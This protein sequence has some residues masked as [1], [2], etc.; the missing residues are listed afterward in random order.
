MCNIVLSQ[1]RPSC[2]EGRVGATFSTFRKLI[3]G[4]GHGYRGGGGVASFSGT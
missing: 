4:H 2:F 1:V 3:Y